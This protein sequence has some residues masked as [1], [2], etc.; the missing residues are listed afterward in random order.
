MKKYIGVKM[1]EAEPKDG[2]IKEVLCSG[3]K[4]VYQNGYESWSPK[5]VFEEAYREC[6][7]LNFGLAFEGVK[8]G[9]GMRLPQWSPDVVIRCQRPDEHSKMTA[10]YLY[11]ESRFGRIP[12]KETMI[13]LFAENW[14]L[15]D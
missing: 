7:G 5:E 4:V 2:I 13:E 10:P 15:V 11:V 8:K 12:W 6:D 14:Q 3:Y 9:M 1:V